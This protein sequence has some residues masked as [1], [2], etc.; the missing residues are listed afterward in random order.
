MKSKL[1]LFMALLV[2]ASLLLAA[3]GPTEEP[4]V[5]EPVAEE[6]M[7][8]EPMEEPEEEPMEEPEE[9]P[10]AELGSEEYPI[11]ML[12][13]PSVN[14]DFMI[15]SGD[16]IEAA[17]LDATGLYF[18]VSVP[19][20]YAATIEEMCASPTDT[21]GFI[22][23]QGYV[24]ANSLCGVEVA[25]APERYGWNVYWAQF[26]VARDSEFETLEDLAG[27]SWAFPDTGSTSGYLYP[28]ALFESMGIEVG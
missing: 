7:E 24:L 18:D 20:S 14:I 5:E 1:Y 28:S 25:L 15:A 4:A 22:P 16:A 13:V 17:M 10:M 27:A 9:E 8:E 11:K 12:F 21:V 2:V 3:C 26:I 23:A 19:T 6:P